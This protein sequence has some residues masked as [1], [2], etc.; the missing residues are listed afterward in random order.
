MFL[1]CTDAIACCLL[2]ADEADE[3]PWDQ[4]RDW[5]SGDS[6]EFSEWLDS[7]REDG[8]M[9]NDDVTMVRLEIFG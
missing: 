9:K 3:S 5:R 1:L 4:I 8:R 6:R 7:A 2:R